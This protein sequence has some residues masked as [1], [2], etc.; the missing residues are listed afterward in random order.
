M[1]L[2]AKVIVV[3]TVALVII[4]FV[5]IF[6]GKGTEF[7]L[8]Y[9]AF[10]LTRMILGFSH[11]LHFKSELVCVTVGALTFWGLTYLAPSA[12]ASIIM[13]LVYGAALA[14]G[15]R[16]Y[17]ELHD[18]MM[19]RKAAKTDRYAMLYTSFKG[20]LDPRH[21]KALMRFRGRN[22]PKDIEAVQMYMAKE[23]I[24]YIAER[25]KEPTRSIDRRLSEIADDLYSKR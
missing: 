21:I 13:S 8:M 23:K 16:V 19:Y 1:L 10:C 5:P 11:S 6:I 17:W 15:F 20:N 3:Q 12:E 2:K 14:I 22:E 18:L 24:D 7:A 9:L 25:L 4:A